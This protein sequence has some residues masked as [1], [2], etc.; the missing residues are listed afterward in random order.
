MATNNELLER[1]KNAVPRGVATMT[2]VFAERAENSEIWDVE[3]R[4]FIDFGGGIAVLNTG[5]CHP[6]VNKAVM[7]QQQ[8]FTH[9]AFQVMAY[10]NYV[11]VAE[12]L[13]SLVPINNAK[14]I[15][16]NS[17]AEA[18]ENAVKIAR[19]YT[20]RDTV[21]AFNGGF[22]GRS[23]LAMA[24]TG[25]IAPYKAKFGTMP[26]GVYH[27]PFPI[28]HHGISEDDSFD[29]LTW[30]FKVDVEAT[31]VAAIIIEPVQ[32]EGGFYVAS[33]AFMKRLRALCDE[34]GILLIC[35]EVQTGFARTGKMFATEYAGIEPDLMTL[36]KSIAGGYPLSA[37]VGKA[38]IMDAPEPGG[39][40]ST[41]GG[42]PL[43]C[44]AALAVMDVIEEEHLCERANQIG[45]RLQARIK[46]LKARDDL[47]AIGDIRG[48]G[49]M[50]AFELVQHRGGHTAD[51]E[52]TKKLVAEA[53]KLGL[54]LLSCGIFA[55]TIRILVPL[56]VADETIDEGLDILTQALTNCV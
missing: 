37:V 14:T 28:E 31:R 21:I 35:D 3:G 55:N 54:V 25:K 2:S 12:R 11:E 24:L 49:A 17:G 40:G 48:L 27:V 10:A 9:T 1:R 6:K 32:G 7:E 4:R 36:A 46:S 52:R 53:E 30:L 33:P 45:E 34:H 20:G 13:N 18:V 44:A 26:G 41:Y 5:H 50:V 19:A 56:T 15:L 38:E 23:F 47:P 16:L 29:A 43:G 22:H 51:T 42:N 39:L 8:R